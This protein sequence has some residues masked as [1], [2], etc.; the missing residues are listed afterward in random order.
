MLDLPWGNHRR[1]PLDQSMA[2]IRRSCRRRLP[3]LL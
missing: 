1:P 3:M 2:I